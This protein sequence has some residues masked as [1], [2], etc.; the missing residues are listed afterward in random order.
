MGTAKRAEQRAGI[1]IKPLA[2]LVPQPIQQRQAA[3]DAGNQQRADQQMRPF[4]AEILAAELLAHAA[5]NIG[6]GQRGPA[7]KEAHHDVG[8]P[9]NGDASRG[10]GSGPS[11]SRL[12]LR[13]AASRT[14]GLRS[15]SAACKAS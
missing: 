8:S 6:V 1:V 14:S 4:E 13:S 3:D 9:I 12:R 11:T 10:G 2:A 5:E 7:G 15:P